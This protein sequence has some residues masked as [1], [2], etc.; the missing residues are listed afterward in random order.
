MALTPLVVEPQ[1]SSHAEEPELRTRK[2]RERHLLI[3]TNREFEAGLTTRDK[4]H[5]VVRLE[6]DS[7][8][9]MRTLIEGVGHFIKGGWGFQQVCR[10]SF[11]GCRIWRA[12]INTFHIRSHRECTQIYFIRLP[13][14][15]A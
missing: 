4:L 13:W 15:F 9:Q 2:R 10:K 3:H 5:L 12:M 14:T 11:T 6:L 8:L 7:E 1:V